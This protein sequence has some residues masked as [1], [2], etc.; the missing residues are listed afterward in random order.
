MI[1]LN[2]QPFYHA[3]NL[4][5]RIGENQHKTP[6]APKE[7]GESLFHA[8]NIMKKA[9]RRKAFGQRKNAVLCIKISVLLWRRVR[10]SNPR[11]LSGSQHFECFIE[12][13]TC[14]KYGA[15]PGSC[16]KRKMPENQAFPD[17][18]RPSCAAGAGARKKSRLSPIWERILHFGEKIG[19]KNKRTLRWKTPQPLANTR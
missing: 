6:F 4:N 18:R 17:K 15:A 16:R 9:L 8:P 14:R 1:S 2:R 5:L 3:P 19:E 13:G 7:Q 11:S 12:R 10:D